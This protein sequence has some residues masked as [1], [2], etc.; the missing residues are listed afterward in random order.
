MLGAGGWEKAAQE[1]LRDLGGVSRGLTLLDLGAAL[2][3]RGREAQAM[4]LFSE[5]LPLLERVPEHL[6]WGL[7]NMAMVCLRLGRLTEADTFFGRASR[8]K[9]PFARRALCGQAAARRAL[10]E[11]AR[12]ASLYERAADLARTAEDEDDLRQALRGLGHTWR[13]AGQVPRALE[14]L[15]SA[16]VAV[17]ADRQAG[18]S[19][20]NVDLAAA[21]VNWPQRDADL[22]VAQI[23]DL[24]SRTGPLGQEDQG[25]ATLVR[26]E[27]LRR[28]GQPDAACALLRT[29]PREPLWMREEAHAFA[30]LFALLPEAERPPPL[31]RC[32]QLVVALRVMGVPD[33]RLGGRPLPLAPAPLV[34]LCALVEA[35]GRLTTET[36]MDVLRPGGDSA[37]TERQK[38]QRVSAVMRQ[39][40]SALGWE[41]S[42]VSRGGAYHLDDTVR[43]TSDVLHALQRGERIEAYCTGIH[44]PWAAAREQQLILGGSDDWLDH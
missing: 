33:V 7:N 34:A 25:R 19:W 35:G 18:V 2:S 38:G 28:T 32:A 29:L 21:Y 17:A 36:L 26:A 22:D 20:V 15:Q 10:G 16:A 8:L 39:L 41:A 3:H 24:L 42:V 12:A 14:P 11:W 23:G 4:R 30:D 1:A 6:D 44:L 27:V 40:R 31:P 9:T 37:R 43:W 5:A 13:L